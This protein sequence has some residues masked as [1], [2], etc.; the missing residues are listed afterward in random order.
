M[1]HIVYKILVFTNNYTAVNMQNLFKEN[2]QITSMM[3]VSLTI[4]LRDLSESIQYKGVVGSAED[5]KTT[6]FKDN[7]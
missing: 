6:S 2:L 3:H 7:V 4:L 1:T 5:F